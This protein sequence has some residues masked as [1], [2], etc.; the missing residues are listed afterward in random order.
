MKQSHRNAPPWLTYVTVKGDTLRHNPLG[1]P[2]ERHVPVFLPPSYGGSRRFPVIYLLAGFAST[3]QSFLNYRFGRKTLPGQLAELMERGKMREVIV[4]MPDCMTRYGGSQYVD[5]AATGN[6]ETYL[7]R[8]LIPAIDQSLCTLPQQRHRAVAGKSSGGFG[9]LRLAMRHP[10]LFSAMAC[11][12]GDMHFELS[13]RSSF[14]AAARSLAKYTGGTKEFLEKWEQAHKPVSSDFPLL[15]IMAMAA[16]YSPDP[17]K[18]PPEN[19]RF[20]FD[21]RTLD[22]IPEVWEEWLAFDPLVMLRNNDYA[23]ALGNLRLLYLDCG[24]L[25]EY[26]LQF[27]HRKF[28]AQLEERGIAHMYE[29]FP[30]THGDTSYRYATSLPKLADAIACT[31]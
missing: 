10:D 25:D 22:I 20:P 26:N 15:D 19:M 23:A 1:D 4:V 28:S 24:S 17:S 2:H 14:P 29:E 12:S 13:Y 3:G 11:H 8:E 6:Y 27:G 9:A 16:C 5:S 31:D 18:A 21:P 30:D 7:C